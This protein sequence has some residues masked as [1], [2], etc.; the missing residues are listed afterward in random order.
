MSN[1]QWSRKKDEAEGLQPKSMGQRESE[2]EV[3]T[4]MDGGFI[5]INSGVV[6][7][8]L[9]LITKDPFTILIS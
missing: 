9:L 2:W 3:K 7:R 8:S 6:E 5:N 4:D 1:P